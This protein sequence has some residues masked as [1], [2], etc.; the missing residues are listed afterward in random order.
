MNLWFFQE[1]KAEYKLRPQKI[2]LRLPA[3]WV[4]SFQRE[5]RQ[6]KTSLS[7]VIRSKI[8]GRKDITLDESTEPF[9]LSLWLQKLEEK[10]I[11][12]QTRH[13]EPSSSSPQENPE[14]IETLL[15]VRELLFERNAQ[16]LRRIDDK[17][18]RLFG[19]DRRKIL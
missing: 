17:V 11:A 8:A 3:A 12:F 13:S 19:K 14:L 4:A 5:A 9:E 2:N 6:E 18:E 15:I 7:N 1:Y 16:A 10:L